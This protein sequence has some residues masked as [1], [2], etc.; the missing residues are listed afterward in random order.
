MKNL[1]GKRVLVTGGSSG[2]GWAIAQEMV[3]SGAQVTITG[4][5]AQKLADAARREAA[6]DGHVCDVTD[7]AAIVA[8]RDGL[9]ADGGVDVLVN[10]AGIMAFFQVL[11]RFPV[12]QQV[13]EIDIDVVGPIK[14]I[15]HFLPSLLERPSLIINVSS[16]LA[17]VPFARAPVY[18]GCKSFIHAYTQCLREQ[19]KHTSVQVVELLPPVVDTPLA[20][21]A[22][23]ESP[24]PMMPPDKLAEAL[25]N[26]LRRGDLEITPGATRQLKWLSRLAPEFI[27]RQ[28]NKQS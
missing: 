18:S 24:F 14:M 22:P 6:I 25:M 5:D 15:E 27:F 4:R 1:T 3:R 8:L 9:R 7:E 16:G 23:A 13:K 12:A 28:L 2:I 11:D 19:L 17:Y 26:G 21:G 10:N 20:R